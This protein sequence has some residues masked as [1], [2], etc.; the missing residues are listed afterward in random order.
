MRSKKPDDEAHGR[1]NGAGLVDSP[2][3]CESE[4]GESHHAGDEPHAVENVQELANDV[5]GCV[6]TRLQGHK[7]DGGNYRE[8]YLSA[9][10]DN[11]R[12]IKKRAKQS[13][14]GK[15]IQG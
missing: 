14:H 7:G 1:Q 4:Q 13:L 3:R 6:R 11:E 9:E 8:K 5:A 12:E 2:C 10:P 15:R